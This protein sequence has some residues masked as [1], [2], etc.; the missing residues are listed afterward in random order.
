MSGAVTI[1]RLDDA[2][3]P[4]VM[5][6]LDNYAFHASPPF[7]EREGWEARWR[8]FRGP[9][10]YAAFE[11][12]APVATAA[13]TPLTQQVRGAMFPAGGILGVVTHP[14]RRNRGHSREVL[15]RVLEV[16]REEG[17][18]LSCLYPFRESFY[19]RLG[20]VTFPQYRA[21][22]F[23][24]SALERLAKPD[25]GGTVDLVLI[26]E[27]YDAYR[28]YLRRL[29]QRVHGF[30]LHEEEQRESAQQNR[31]WL[32]LAR[33]DGQVVGVM[34][35]QIRG[36]KIADFALRILRFYYDTSQARYLLLQWIAQ[37]SGQANQVEMWLPPYE[38]PE[39]WLADL[40]VATEV[41]WF[42]PMGRIV[43]VAGL[44]SMQIGSGRFSAQIHDRI[45]TW[46]EGVW[47]FESEGGTLAI[48]R[49]S[50]AGGADC[51]LAIQGLS[52]LVYG[53]H[54]PGD[55]QWRG[56]GEP[57]PEVQAIMRRMFPPRLPYLHE[58]F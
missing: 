48:R 33:L 17:R 11:D 14:A 3:A 16:F 42:P 27:G 35:Y 19:E 40:R 45:C 6:W 25:L 32:A 38:L 28:D 49:R 41:P 26:G 36:E 24:T 51:Q 39:T 55:F 31:S 22:R 20:Y 52:A 10:Y 47:Q 21:A 2:E 58:Q 56:W 7:P 30:A 9:F 46:N 29:Q 53:T 4:E 18:P 12:S 15:T 50:A 37:H 44:D 34:V 1:R 57:S 43:D 23:H 54:D 5:Y 13:G 8:S